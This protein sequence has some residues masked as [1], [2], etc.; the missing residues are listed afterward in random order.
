MDTILDSTAGFA[1]GYTAASQK[2]GRLANFVGLSDSYSA[3]IGSLGAGATYSTSG[4]YIGYSG[5]AGVGG[6]S[7]AESALRQQILNLACVTY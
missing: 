5:Q 6:L 2:F 7:K 1:A 4:E 3:S